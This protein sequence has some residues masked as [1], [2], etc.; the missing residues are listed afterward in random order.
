M[1]SARAA[2]SARPRCVSPVRFHAGAQS[3]HSC[4]AATTLSKSFTSIPL[5]TKRGRQW[6][7]AIWTRLNGSALIRVLPDLLV[8]GAPRGKA[9]ALVVVFEGVGLRAGQLAVELRA[10]VVRLSRPA[11]E[12]R[13]ARCRRRE[14]L[15]VV[16]P[17]S[18]G[19]EAAQIE[20][21]DHQS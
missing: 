2:S 10:A 6:P 17:R 12:D 18:H 9:A 14:H 20:I 3:F 11:G 4:V 19:I 5:A 16:V 21:G 1:C 7:A 13:V 8:F 15:L